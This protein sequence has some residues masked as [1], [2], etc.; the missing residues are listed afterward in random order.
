M[1]CGIVSACQFSFSRPRET[2][3]GRVVIARAFPGRANLPSIVPL[4]AILFTSSAVNRNVQACPEG[5]PLT[6]C[7][8]WAIAASRDSSGSSGDGVPDRVAGLPDC[9]FEACREASG[10][11]DSSKRRR[12]ALPKK[13]ATVGLGLV[14]GQGA[15]RRR[16]TQ[17][18]WMAQ[19]FQQI[20][21]GAVRAARGVGT[22]RS[23]GGRAVPLPSAP[24]SPLAS[25]PPSGMPFADGGRGGF[26]PQFL[27]DRQT[28]PPCENQHRQSRLSPPSEPT[29]RKWGWLPA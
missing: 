21:E 3:V 29:L 10:R 28:L 25:T 15:D 9:P 5:W 4:I 2:H 13:F 8:G 12:P 17:M 18:H 27:A 22:A 16:T 6:V 23:G 20:G 26:R 7:Q 1:K 24:G 14:L 11:T 19:L